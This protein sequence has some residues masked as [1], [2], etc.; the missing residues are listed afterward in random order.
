LAN[1]ASLEELPTVDYRFTSMLEKA[2]SEILRDK[3]VSNFSVNKLVFEES[4]L[5][6]Y[7]TV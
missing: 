4:S 1:F 2:I 3:A 7:G 5:L 6:G